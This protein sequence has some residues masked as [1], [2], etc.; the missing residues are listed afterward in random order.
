ERQILVEG[1]A[2][3]GVVELHPHPLRGDPTPVRRD[4]DAM[5]INVTPGHTRAELPRRH[6]PDAERV[7]VT[8]GRQ[9][10]AVRG[11]AQG[12]NLVLTA[13]DLADLRAGGRLPQADDLIRARTGDELPVRR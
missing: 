11:D 13:V 1:V 3:D 10:S 2:R 8:A 6:F 12:P 4:D 5:P 9:A 7:V